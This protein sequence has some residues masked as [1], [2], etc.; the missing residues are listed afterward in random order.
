MVRDKSVQSSSEYLPRS[1]IRGDRSG[2]NDYV[3]VAKPLNLKHLSFNKELLKEE[4]VSQFNKYVTQ[5][6]HKV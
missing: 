2:C 3:K 5:V 6:S 1:R 4:S